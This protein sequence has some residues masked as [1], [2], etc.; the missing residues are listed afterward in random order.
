M[1]RFSDVRYGDFMRGVIVV[2]IVGTAVYLM[3]TGQPIPDLLTVMFSL[4]GAYYFGKGFV[5]S[6][7]D[8]IKKS[9]E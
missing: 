1:L 7:G 3:V 6:F 2:P 4:I 8:V 5:Q 9:S